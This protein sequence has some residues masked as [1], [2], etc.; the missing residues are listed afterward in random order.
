MA[1]MYWDRLRSLLGE[2]QGATRELVVSD[3]ERSGE[4]T[5]KG[6][7][8]QIAL[9][10][11]GRFERGAQSVRDAVRSAGDVWEGV[12]PG[13]GMGEY[14]SYGC[15]GDSLPWVKQKLVPA[16]PVIAL[17]ADNGVLDVDSG[18]VCASEEELDLVDREISLRVWD[19]DVAL[20]P[21]PVAERLVKARK[22]MQKITNRIDVCVKILAAVEGHGRKVCKAALDKLKLSLEKAEAAAERA[23]KN[24]EAARAKREK[25]I[26]A[27]RAKQAKV[28]EMALAKQEKAAE[29]VRAKQAK[30]GEAVRASAAKEKQAKKKNKSTEAQKKF[31]D[32]FLHKKTALE[33][34]RTVS[35]A[36]ALVG[37]STDAAATTDA[38]V[39]QDVILV[40][41]S[42]ADLDSKVVTIAT[43]VNANPFGA[44]KRNTG[45]FPL[46]RDRELMT[47]SWWL[48]CGILFPSE[49]DL[50]A[51]GQL[52]SARHPSPSKPSLENL[53]DHLAICA[54]RR[55]VA[56]QTLNLTLR[57]YRSARTVMR[58]DR[59]PRFVSKRADGRGRTSENNIPIKLLQFAENYRPAFSGTVKRRSSPVKGRRPLAKDPDLDYNYDSEEEWEDEDGDDGEN[60]SDADADKETEKED[61]ELKILFGSDDEEDDD[62]LD[63]DGDDISGDEGSDGRGDGENCTIDANKR[64]GA[65]DPMAVVDLSQ[66]STMKLQLGS[67]GKRKTSAYGSVKKRRRRNGNSQMLQKVVMEGVAFADPGQPSPLDRFPV[68]RSDGDPVITMYNPVADAEVEAT[69]AKAG[70]GRRGPRSHLGADGRLDL[71]RI[72]TGCAVGRDKVI[73]QFWASRRAQGLQ[74]PTRAELGRVIA[75]I[76]VREKR[77]G[78]VRARWYVT[79]VTVAAQLRDLSPDSRQTSIVAVL[80]SSS[81]ATPRS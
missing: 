9:A 29:A 5:G 18:A 79:D 52:F 41:D 8:G 64:G 19:S 55:L 11:Q 1:D 47:V 23:R 45:P 40:Y 72:L 37:P 33:S 76:A 71:A 12:W 20:L 75:E 16:A 22:R 49:E 34:A 58:D 36:P 6:V 30:T 2:A 63:D 53:R 10:L 69:K 39:R 3:E 15:K 77:P 67:I 57:C 42:S 56:Q 80:D 7:P 27:A 62:F 68:T 32:R 26:E 78:D 24:D 4:W 14:V 48:M 73:E 54:N 17:D 61:A 25:A 65:G 46:L 43:D 66:S 50:D 21:I 70:P 60:L 44:R 59:T 13:E 31:M 38:T 51:E 81:P 28:A 74:L 35:S